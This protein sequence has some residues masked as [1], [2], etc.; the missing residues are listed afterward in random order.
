[1]LIKT[2]Y[3][4]VLVNYY[5]QFQFLKLKIKVFIEFDKP[6]YLKLMHFVEAMLVSRAI[7]SCIMV[8]ET[9][10]VFLDVC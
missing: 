9:S 2:L 7:Q 5:F 1:M 3:L 6:I 4:V 10:E 8:C